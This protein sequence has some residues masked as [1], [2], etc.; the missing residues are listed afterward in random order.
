MKEVTTNVL[1]KGA[2]YDEEFNRV[3]KLIEETYG[4]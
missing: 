2:N 3:R 1:F 4:G